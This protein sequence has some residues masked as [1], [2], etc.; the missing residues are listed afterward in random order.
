M[1]MNQIGGPTVKLYDANNWH[2]WYRNGWVF[3]NAQGVSNG[4]GSW[5]STT[6]PYTLPTGYRPSSEIAAAC[7]AANGGTT[8]TTISVSADGVI[9]ISNTGSSGTTNARYGSISFPVGA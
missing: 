5:D 3:V 9:K 6:C 8:T 1:S 4:S 7:I 2:V